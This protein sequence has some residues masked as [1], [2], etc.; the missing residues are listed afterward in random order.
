MR[1]GVGERKN[2]ENWENWEN[3]KLGER[4]DGRMGEWEGIVKSTVK[5]QSKA[6]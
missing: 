1:S 2:W 4:E 3:G 6:K 5:Q